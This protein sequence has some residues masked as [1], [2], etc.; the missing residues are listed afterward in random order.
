MRC[1]SDTIRM[2]IGSVVSELHLT[3]PLVQIQPVAEAHVKPAL[4]IL[5]RIASTDDLEQ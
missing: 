1:N 2:T 3:W 5:S 4:G